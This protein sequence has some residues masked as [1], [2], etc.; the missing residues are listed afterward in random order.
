MIITAGAKLS[1][2]RKLAKEKSSSAISSASKVST[3]Y[4]WAC[5]HL[6]EV[7]HLFVLRCDGSDSHCH[8]HHHHHHHHL[9]KFLVEWY[10]LRKILPIPRLA[11]ALPHFV[12]VSEGEYLI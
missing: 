1:M 11:E 7:P 5:T 2:A 9:A 3:Q 12:S 8:H 6:V 10:I 4:M